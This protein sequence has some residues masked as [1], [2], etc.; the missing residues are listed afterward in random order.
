VHLVCTPSSGRHRMRRATPPR[1]WRVLT[2]MM[3]INLANLV[4]N[5]VYSIM[6][7]FFPQVAAAK[8][9]SPAWIGF[10][11]AAF[12]AIVF[13]CAPLATTLMGMRGTRPVFLLGLAILSLGTLALATAP[14]LPD[15]PPFAAFCMAM[16][17]LQGGGSALEEAAAYVLIAELAAPTNSVTFFLGLTELSTGAGYMLGNRSARS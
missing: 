7:A 8:E 6:D 5:S 14:I 10:I 3:A 17:V 9:L 15:G 1:L 13:L 2:M 11:F 12:P 4:S 16:R